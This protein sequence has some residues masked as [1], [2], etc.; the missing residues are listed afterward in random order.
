MSNL[1]EAVPAVPASKPRAAGRRSQRGGKVNPLGAVAHIALILWALA[2]AGPLIWVIL[3]SFKNNTELFLGK[4][5]ALPHHFSFSTYAHAWST[6]HIGQ[7]FLN[8]VIVVAFSTAGTMILGAMAAYVL[9]RY[10]FIGNRII[11]YVFI[12]GLAFPTFMALAPLFGILQNIKVPSDSGSLLGTQVGLIL[13]YIAYS[14]SFTVF[15]LVAFF[16]TLP[17]EIEEAATVDGAGHIRRFWQIM[18]PMARSGLVS[19]TIFNIVGQWNQYLLPTVVMSGP[20][21]DSKW[22]LT[23]GIANISTSAGYH[24]DWST[25]FAAL[26]LTILPMVVVYAIFQRQIQSGL[27]SGAVK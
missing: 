17:K 3:A 13:V 15:F 21:S 1:T 20:G 11:Y 22:V 24:A 18:M 9:A 2:T 10:K 14:L 5:F 25:L 12:S 7:Y 8:S 4:P 19:I 27:T 26:T 23:Q 6:A 16:Q